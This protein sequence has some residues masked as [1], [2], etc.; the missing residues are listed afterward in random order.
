MFT[1]GFTVARRAYP[2]TGNRVNNY[3]VGG[4]A[5][6]AL[7]VLVFYNRVQD[8]TLLLVLSVTLVSTLVVIRVPSKRVLPSHKHL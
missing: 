3:R 1:L 7:C 8:T 2:S 6:L 5:T 4:M